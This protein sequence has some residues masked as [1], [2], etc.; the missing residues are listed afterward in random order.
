MIEVINKI[1]KMTVNQEV[2][3]MLIGIGIVS[4]IVILLVIHQFNIDIY[5]SCLSQATSGL[6]QACENMRPT[7]LIFGW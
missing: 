7:P 2:G 1:N 3:L 6:T 5:N 4:A